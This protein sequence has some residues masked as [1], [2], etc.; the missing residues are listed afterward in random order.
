VLVVYAIKMV[1]YVA[2]KKYGAA[3]FMFCMIVNGA[4]TN[5]VKLKELKCGENRLEVKYGEV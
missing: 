5:G 1:I 4:I 2:L 3:F